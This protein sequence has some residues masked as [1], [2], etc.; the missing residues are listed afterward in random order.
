M[1]TSSPVVT[2]G[3]LLSAALIFYLYF[4]SA[5]SL[6]AQALSPR[7]VLSW[8]GG[9]TLASLLVS[10]TW[11]R[12]GSAVEQ[13]QLAPARRTLTDTQRRGVKWGTAAGAVAGF[14]IGVA[15]LPDECHPLTCALAPLPVTLATVAGGVAGAGVG[16]IVG[17]IVDERRKQQAYLRLIVSLPLPTN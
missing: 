7:P 9:P 4:A 2:F 14:A 8:S 1:G 3:P 11:D 16:L 15:A 17:S 12:R 5:P 10:E 13:T 6:A